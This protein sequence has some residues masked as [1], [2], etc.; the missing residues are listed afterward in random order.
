MDGRPERPRHQI[1]PPPPPD[2][3]GLP[4]KTP[5]DRERF[6]F[7]LLAGVIISEF[8]I[9]ILGAGI[10]GWRLI[11]YGARDCPE[12]MQ[13]LQT[14][15]DSTLNLILALLGGAAIGSSVSRGKP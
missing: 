3:E 6:L 2:D 14:A 4:P 12:F 7:V 9:Y 8:A 11:F 13:R 5:F 1:P 15:T 10:C